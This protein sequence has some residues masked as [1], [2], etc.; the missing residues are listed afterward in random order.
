[1]DGKPRF[2]DDKQTLSSQPRGTPFLSKQPLHARLGMQ[3]RRARLEAKLTQ[4]RLADA[5]GCSLPTVRQAEAGLG[6]SAL[7]LLLASSLGHELIGRTTSSSVHPG[8]GLA[9]LRHRR[10]LSRRA[11][12]EVAGVSVPTVA[13]VERGANVHMV[14]LARISV[15][16]AAGL[17]LR[18]TT[19]PASLF[20]SGAATSS[21]QQCWTTPPAL[22]AK[23][24][25]V[26]GGPFTLD[27]CSPTLDKK[28]APVR[29]RVHLTEA[30]DGLAADWF[31]TVYCNPPYGRTI[32]RWVSK[33]RSSVE[34]GQ[35]SYVVALVPARS[36]TKWW[37][38]DVA[39]FADVLMLKGRLYFGD[40]EAP[41]PFPSALVCWGLYEAHRRAVQAAFPDAWYVSAEN[42]LADGLAAAHDDREHA[43]VAGTRQATTTGSV[44]SQ[45]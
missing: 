37:H 17:Y 19:G 11:L 45:A 1:M 5:A 3:L 35:A 29:A 8:V 7:F 24:Y 44:V 26:F 33:C 30:D 28:Q 16:L 4:R 22:L 32:G 20:W 18:S 25:A 39:G 2:R 42:G 14:S 15:V 43:V 27:P 31:G 36:D 12:A 34:A 10:G 21:A 38:A 40:G 41:A 23:L 9:K 13:A 6:G